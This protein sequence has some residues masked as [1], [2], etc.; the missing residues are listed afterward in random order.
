MSTGLRIVRYPVAR[1]ATLWAAIALAGCV[2]P[3]PPEPAG[4]SFTAPLAWRESPG[5]TA[6]IERNWWRGYGDPVLADLVEHALASNADIGIAVA[7]VAEAR[8]QERL[9]RSQM[10]P[11]LDAV[12]TGGRSRSLSALG[13][14]K[15]SDSFSPQ[16]EAAYQVDLFGR[17]RDLR[18]AARAGVAATEAARDAA[19]LTVAASTARA[20]VTLRAYDAQL[21]VVRQT[22]Q[23]REAALRLARQRADA[24][25]TSQLEFEQARAEYEATAQ[26]VPQ[27]ELAVSRQENAL[28]LLLGDTPSVGVPR[29]AALDALNIPPVPAVLPAELLRRRPDLAQAEYQ[30][31]ATDANL[32]AARKA[33][34][35]QIQLSA[36][37][38][39]LFA[40]GVD[41]PVQL[42]SLG[43]SVLAPLF[44][45]GRLRAGTDIAAAQRDQAAFAYRRTALTAFREVNDN[46]AALSRLQRQAQSLRAQRDA[47]ASTLRH[48][49]NRYRAG[50]S[51]YLEQLDAQRQLLNAE[52]NLVQAEA[53]RLNAS[54][55]LYQAMG[56]GWTDA[57]R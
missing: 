8:G 35:P 15:V 45:G 2:G 51:T 48:A 46:L 32:S 22:L 30:L 25:Y 29:G 26:A 53:D 27:A 57:S 28:M 56:G 55:A 37:S 49:T 38:G 13:T 24:G 17:L 47:L 54:I 12:A 1:L 11:T 18:E 23:A 44:E 7:R 52:L 10:L 5:P 20:Y 21:Q 3:R 41:G 34:L 33:F 14:E 19:V 4:A 39:L 16:F 42:W 43:A 31:A 50:Y 9:A 40:S 36:S 6:Q